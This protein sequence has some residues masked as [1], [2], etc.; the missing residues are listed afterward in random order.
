MRV[1]Q[2]NLRREIHRFNAVL[3]ETA[4]KNVNVL[5][6]NLVDDFRLLA[7]QL[8]ALSRSADLQHQ[9]MI[10]VQSAASQ[11]Y[12]CLCL[13]TAGGELR[14]MAPKRL[15]AA[16]AV[17]SKVPPPERDLPPGWKAIFNAFTK[18]KS[19]LLHRSKPRIAGLDLVPVIYFGLKL[20]ATISGQPDQYLVAE[21]DLR[22]VWRR[23]DHMITGFRGHVLVAAESGMII[24]HT[25]RAYIGRRIPSP[26]TPVVQG[27]AGRTS[28]RAGE[29]VMLA[30][31]SPVSKR[32]GW[33]VVV[34]QPE[35]TALA[36]VSRIAW[37]ALGVSILA[38]VLSGGAA[39]F[40]ARSITRP[41]EQLT[42]TA[43]HITETGRLN[44]AIPVTG[45]DEAG[46]LAASFNRMIDGLKSAEAALRESEQRFAFAMDAAK[47]GI[48]DWNI[49][50]GEVYYSPGYA[51]ML[52]FSPDETTGDIDFWKERLHPED[53]S[54]ALKANYDCL[55]NRREDFEIEF[56]MRAKNGEWR[57]ILGR[58]NA[59]V[60]DETGRALRMIG[61]HT[62]ITERKKTEAQ[63]R[64]TYKMEAVGTLAGGIAHDFNNI[65]AAVIGFAE[66]SIAEVPE[67]H[68][69]RSNLEQILASS[70]RARDLVKQL[71]GFSRRQEEEQRP[72]DLKPI[73]SEAL[74]LLRATLPATIEITSEWNPE[75]KPVKADPTRIHQL[76]INLCKNA[77]DAMHPAGG[78]LTVRLDPVTETDAPAPP[79]S[80]RTGE[81]IV[82]ITVQDTG[83][84]IPPEIRDRIFDPFFT[85]KPVGA[86]T[87][88]GLSVVHGI[89]QR[90]GGAVTVDSAPGAGAAFSV[91]LP[92]VRPQSPPPA[93]SPVTVAPTGTERILFVD[94]EPA[95]T[96][97]ARRL[98]RK[99]GYDPAVETTAEDALA[100]FRNNP[101]SFD[102]VITDMTMPRMTGIELAGEVLRIRPG[103]PIILCTGYSDQIDEEKARHLGLRRLVLKP[104]S[105]AEMSRTIRAV[106]DETNPA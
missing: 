9:T 54:A 36:P 94:D 34:A 11:K 66:I 69:V 103:T 39:F 37:V 15:P 19:G 96:G 83:P 25:D 80:V 21:M 40:F 27:Y 57:W 12:R 89:V 2:H 20:P 31:Y 29:Q 56:R 102:L 91:F 5:Y 61:T 95:I 8:A 90:H 28:Y 52:G 38:I 59:M 93:D 14:A 17:Y 7:A 88:M 92:A 43:Q 76:I 3:A 55:E 105:A 35:E 100:T 70:M 48:W 10:E 73:L 99:L 67:H 81:G 65:L 86:G 62:D 4:A 79:A 6:N 33:G 82:K 46:R 106:L 71:L 58:G 85:T 74:K 23:T 24:S 47:D 42:E 77:A 97:Y 26:L 18:A 75:V 78:V 72:V 101:E 44:S 30:G 104:L 49:A 32:S 63:L 51:A 68:P 53:R 16:S 1:A 98:L 13:F 50:S 41:L 87:G 84:G 64:Q 45:S 22:V 60:R